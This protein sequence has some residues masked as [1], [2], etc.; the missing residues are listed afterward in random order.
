M[1]KVR[2]NSP[3][4]INKNYE[5]M[6]ISTIL[7]SFLLATGM[8]ATAANS[9]TQTATKTFKGIV[10]ADNATLSNVMTKASDGDVFL[11][12]VF[13][14]AFEGLEPITGS[15]YIIKS[16]TTLTTKWKVAIQGSA[17]ITAL[18]GDNDGGV[19]V[20]GNLADEV[21]FT[22]T[23]GES[24]TVE[25]YKESDAFVSDQC[26]AFFA[27]YDKDGK[28][29]AVNTIVPKHNADLDTLDVTFYEGDVYCNVRNLVFTD[30]NLYAALST[31]ST[32]T[33]TDGTA[34]VSSGS[35]DAWGIGFYMATKAVVIAS[36]DKDLNVTAFPFYV[37]SASIA[38]GLTNGYTVA[39]SSTTGGN[40]HLYVAIVSNGTVYA[41]AFTHAVE[42]LAFTDNVNEN[43]AGFSIIDIDLS[44]QTAKVVDN[45]TADT[46]QEENPV[47][48]GIAEH[49]DDLVLTGYFCGKLAFNTDVTAQSHYDIFA[50]KVSK[51]GTVGWA[52]A[53]A[54][55]EGEANHNGEYVSDATV[56]GDKLFLGGY[57]Q[58]TSDRTLTDPLYYSIDL[59]NGTFVS[60]TTT[61]YVSGLYAYNSSKL[62]QAT[63]PSTMTDVTFSVYSVVPTGIS[64][65]VADND[66]AEGKIYN[67][68]G[69]RI[70][71]PAKGVYIQNGKKYIAK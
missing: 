16:D 8:T 36:L 62:L 15:S 20:G 44:A 41:T 49:G 1:K 59:A 55:D 29:L 18:V 31:T 5:S 32:I 40:G 69:Q 56:L 19:Y 35:Y 61:D 68:N 39:S 2:D 60:E 12:G 42:T 6:K 24:K 7:A 27:H 23:D 52:T 38:D 33:T 45:W 26:A 25:G 21:V 13:D 71:R 22:G 57:A 64:G 34:S 46:G 4:I 47:I 28:L 53:S 54:Y 3:Y 14:T 50:A 66:T 37:K 67:L 10:T 30:G 43:P 51:T 65:V 63:Q 11:S 48:K 17:T 9:L 58:N 70:S